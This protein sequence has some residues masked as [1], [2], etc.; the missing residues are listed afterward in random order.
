MKREW[1]RLGQL[2]KKEEGVLTS[3]LVMLW[4]YTL[5]PVPWADGRW[6]R[7]FCLVAPWL[8]KGLVP[9]A[10]WEVVVFLSLEGFLHQ[11]CKWGRGQSKSPH[12]RN[13]L[14]VGLALIEQSSAVRHVSTWVPS[15]RKGTF[16]WEVRHSQ[17]D[18]LNY[19]G[20]SLLNVENWQLVLK[21]YFWRI[22]ILK[23]TSSQIGLQMSILSFCHVVSTSFSN[24]AQ[25]P[26]QK[27]V[28]ALVKSNIDIHI[29]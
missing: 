20:S 4:D 14:Y 9:V 28:F 3:S 25:C 7:L 2:S 13:W 24:L 5:R 12:R 16:G 26:E 18:L 6:A 10:Q 21:P 1:R 19:F 11:P 22:Q 15:V 8:H 23:L 17:F 27:I 29:E